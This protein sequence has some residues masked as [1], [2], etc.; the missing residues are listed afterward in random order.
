[1]LKCWSRIFNSSF[2]SAFK[3]D[4]SQARFHYF[5]LSSVI[6]SSPCLL[7]WQHFNGFLVDFARV[8]DTENL[9]GLFDVQ[10]KHLPRQN[11]VYKCWNYGYILSQKQPN[12]P[13]IKCQVDQFRLLCCCCRF[14]TW[15]VYV[16]TQSIFFN[17]CF[18]GIRVEPPTTTPPELIHVRKQVEP[19]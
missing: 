7:V 1:M 14:W 5:I 6:N 12:I 19:S 15:P 16:L 2:D 4:H 13:K 3:S 10:V 9:R 8:S 18:S 11:N 17:F